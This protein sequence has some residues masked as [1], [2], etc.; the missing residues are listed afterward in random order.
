V[1]IFGT[2]DP[3]TS[4][5]QL[6]SKVTTHNT[7]TKTITGTFSGTVKNSA[8]T[9]ISNYEWDLYEAVYLKHITGAPGSVLQELGFMILLNVTELEKG[10]TDLLCLWAK[11][12]YNILQLIDSLPV[13]RQDNE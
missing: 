6:Y 10:I 2:A 8:G 13:I 4:V 9:G 7:S 12:I 1:G 3:Q 5:H 11:T